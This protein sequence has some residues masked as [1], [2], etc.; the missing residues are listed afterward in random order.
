[1]QNAKDILMLKKR[2]SNHSNTLKKLKI[3]EFKPK[4]I[5]KNIKLTASQHAMSASEVKAVQEQFNT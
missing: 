1:M 4:F 2:V 5:T 3:T